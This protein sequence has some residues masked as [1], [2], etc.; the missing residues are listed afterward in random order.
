MP[1]RFN[2]TSYVKQQLTTMPD[3]LYRH[4]S[5]GIDFFLEGNG[6][7]LESELRFLRD[8]RPCWVHLVRSHGAEFVLCEVAA[9]QTWIAH[10]STTFHALETPQLNA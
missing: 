7:I 8:G 1:R 3:W 2:T 6:E 9:T 10:L 5:I 4:F